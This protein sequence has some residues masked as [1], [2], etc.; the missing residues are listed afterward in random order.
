MAGWGRQRC[1][2]ISQPAVQAA[3]F[4]RASRAPLTAG[5]GARI[6]GRRSNAKALNGR[7]VAMLVRVDASERSTAEDAA[8]QA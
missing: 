6:R 8:E 1:G 7:L 3:S 2:A 4:W 5:A